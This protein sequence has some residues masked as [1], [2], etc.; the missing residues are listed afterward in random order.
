MSGRDP[1]RDYVVAL[2]TEVGGHGFRGRL[3]GEVEAH[4]REAV[5]ARIG[6]GVAPDVAVRE[7]IGSCGEPREVAAA[8]EREV[9]ALRRLPAATAAIGAVA[10]AVALLAVVALRPLGADE[11]ESFA[12]P[13]R[14]SARVAEALRLSPEATEVLATAQLLGRRAS[15]CLLQNGGRAAS[16]G[17]ISDP[18]GRARAA[19][20]A[21]IEANDRYVEGQ[22]FREVLAEAQPRFEAAERCITAYGGAGDAAARSAD[23]RRQSAAASRCHRSDGLPA[24]TA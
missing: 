17:G 18:S 5:A 22:A 11:S 19:C 13:D 16:A 23:G 20:L 21:P 14:E 6:A 7:A 15:A 3:L 2:R 1:I 9:P 10:A 4:L 8:L 24:P 12:A